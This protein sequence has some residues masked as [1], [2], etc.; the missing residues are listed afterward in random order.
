MSL[1]IQKVA[2]QKKTFERA[3]KIRLEQKSSKR[4]QSCNFCAAPTEP[5]RI[6]IDFIW[7]TRKNPQDLEHR[8]KQ[9][10][11]PSFILNHPD[12]GSGRKILREISWSNR[13][14]FHSDQT[15][16]PLSNSAYNF[17]GQFAVADKR[18]KWLEVSIKFRNFLECV[19]FQSLS[20]LHSGMKFSERAADL[21]LYFADSGDIKRTMDCTQTDNKRQVQQLGLL[22]WFMQ[23]R[24]RCCFS[25][26]S[27]YL[28]VIA[29]LLKMIL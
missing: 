19:T 5:Y 10:L 18:Q 24:E 29:R 7:V 27:E 28:R 6:M 1:R 20:A 16:C 13:K 9:G 2:D 26:K 17:P 25:L 15:F 4:P 12:G 11:H 8:P 3:K 14:K 23:K 22:L 21:L